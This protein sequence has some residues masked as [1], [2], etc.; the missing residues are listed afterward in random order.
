[1]HAAL[2]EKMK[3]REFITA[4][5]AAAAGLIF[6]GKTSASGSQ[7]KQKRPNILFIMTDQQHAG[8]M[9]C[10]SNKWL[11]TPAMDRLAASGIRFER[12]YAC[13]PVCIPNRFS[14]QT[15]L[16]PSA[17]GMSHNGDSARAAVTDVM[18]QQSLGS[19]FSKAGRGHHGS[20]RFGLSSH[21]FLLTCCE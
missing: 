7:R 17:I 19:L 5:A 10:T 13:N 16:M 8:M 12:A 11:K 20:C 1:V 14:L 2:G 3:R 21:V 18:M 6:E 4:T 9:S 15:G